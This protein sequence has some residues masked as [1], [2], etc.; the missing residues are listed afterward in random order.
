MKIFVEGNMNEVASFVSYFQSQPYFK[1]Q[2]R[3]VQRSNQ[4]E[5]GVV[6][7]I[8]FTTS[9]LKPS[10][11]KNVCVEL[12]T[13]T[14]QVVKID[15]LDPEILKVGDCVTHVKGLNYDIFS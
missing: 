10:I 2:Y 6:A 13:S 11:R 3:K 1:M 9:L 5:G 12:T 7:E 14:G 8:L 15:L 4:D